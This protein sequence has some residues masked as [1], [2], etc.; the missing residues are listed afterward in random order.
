[1]KKLLLLATA[2]LTLSSVNANLLLHESFDYQAGRLDKGVLQ[3]TK[4]WNLTD[5]YYTQSNK[6]DY[7]QVAEGSLS[8]EGYVTAGIGNKAV[9][10]TTTSGN[11][12]ERSFATEA[13]TS[14]SIYFAALINVESL[15]ATDGKDGY[16]MAFANS[17]SAFAPRLYMKTVGDKFQLG[18]RKSG[19]RSGVTT[20]Y[21]TET[22]STK[23]TYL[24]VLEYENVEGEKNDTARL[25]VNPTA[26]VHTPV[27]VST[28]NGTDAQLSSVTLLNSSNA[29]QKVYIDEIKV[30][31]T[32]AELFGEEGG[33]TP[34][35]EE[36][37]EITVDPMSLG[38][39]QGFVGQTYTKTFTVNGKNLKEDITLTSDNAEV[40]LD[41]YTISKD[42]ATDVVVTM[43]I[44]PQT[45]GYG[46]YKITLISGEATANV[47]LLYW[48]MTVSTAATIVELNS[49]VAAASGYENVYI[50]YTGEAVVTYKYNQGG[51]KLYLQDATAG[52]FINDT[53]W[54]DKI[55]QGDKVTNC[56]VYVDPTNVV[57]GM[58]Y[59]GTQTGIEVL[60]HDNEITPQVVTLVELKTSAANYLNKLV[61]V[62]NV[63]LDQRSVTFKGVDADGDAIPDKI[64]QNGSEATL[65]IADGNP[66]V[67]T[68]KPKK[69]DIIG[70]S[71][72][73]AGNAIRLRGLADVISKDSTTA[74]ENIALDMLNGNYEIYT[75]S[76]MRVEALQPG[77]NIIRQGDKTYK[78][79]R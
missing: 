34:P 45:D 8:Y 70:I 47:T 74:I 75:V 25:Y 78:V 66:L 18:I 53:Y 3:P 33:V 26:T 11:Y 60:S 79:V 76:G 61:K 29:P 48:N 63:T 65:S 54:G 51:D 62:E 73:T 32:W 15:H 71:S 6:T 55:K 36:P 20:V 14:G 31:T 77:V 43:N 69:A 50:K 13:I 72:N 68:T 56:M 12:A 22:Y 38:S 30:A 35:A 23:T 67:G 49:L 37:A 16:F 39:L 5:W 7:V 46:D 64:T 19:A 42:A 4:D 21:G 41:K 1:M 57:G 24:V 52:V 58:K 9:V 2:L 44:A 10:N 59:I 40:T 28:Y 27:A 17:G